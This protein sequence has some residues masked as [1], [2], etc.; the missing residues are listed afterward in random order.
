M[1][2]TD[3]N[4]NAT[5]YEYQSGTEWVT[6]VQYADNTQDSYSYD[7][8]GRKL[9]ASNSQGN[10][11][12]QYD[13]RDRL[14]T[15]NQPDGTVLSYQYDNVGNRTQL[16]VKKMNGDEQ[17]TNYSYDALNRLQTVTDATGT[18]RYEY[19]AVGNNTTITYSN[20][21]ITQNQFDELNRITNVYTKD[22]QNNVIGHIAY[23]LDTTGRRTQISELNDRTTQYSYDNLYRLTEESGSG[24]LQ[25][26]YQASYQY[27]VVGNRIQSIIN[28]VTTSYSYDNNDRLLTQANISYSYD[29]NGNLLSKDNA[30]ELNQYVYNLNNRL[31]TVDKADGT[32]L[33]FAY[34]PN[35][36]RIAKSVDGSQTNYVIDSNRTYAQ[37]VNEH[38]QSTW[39]DYSYGLDLLNQQQETNT[40]FYHYDAQGSTKALSSTDGI[41]TDSYAYDAFGKLTK[42]EGASDNNYLYTGE[43]Y[44]PELDNYYLRARYYDQNSARFT[45]LDTWAGDATAPIT[46]NKYLY[47]HSEA[48][49]GSDPTGHMFMMNVMASL[50]IQASLR[51][52]QASGYR[53]TLKKI[54][55]ELACVAIEEIATNAIAEMVSGIYIFEDMSDKKGGNRPYIGKTNNHKVRKKQHADRV[56]KLFSKIEFHVDDILGL[57]NMTDEKKAFDNGLR[58]L[59]Q[60]F[61]DYFED[62]QIST[63]NKYKSVADKPKSFNSKKIRNVLNNKIDLC[64]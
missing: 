18:T 48:V 1:T 43:Q 50:D 16:K 19:D 21:L 42:Q 8:K 11:S 47:G 6:L 4:G 3:F 53:M 38:N 44:D 22:A 20:G 64:P 26:D 23:T 29:D 7:A 27:D 34:N 30:G 28:G 41:I 33:E 56:G 54:G 9:N 61:M 45:Q 32:Q 55:K 62:K 46:Q 58:A 49:N 2:H 10:W 13:S 35:A 57:F 25:A 63:S 14:L 39:S 52:G 17:L 12:Y 36:I 31:A 51:T 5:R 15:E 37:V 60:S 40:A 59:E 24:A